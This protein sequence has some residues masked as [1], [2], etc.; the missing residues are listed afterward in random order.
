MEYNNV[1]RRLELGAAIIAF[2]YSAIALFILLLDFVKTS[3]IFEY[4]DLY[5]IAGYVL[6]YVIFIGLF[7]VEIL[8]AIQLF[9]TPIWIRLDYITGEGHFEGKRKQRIGFIAVSSVFLL[10]FLI[11]SV[12]NNVAI[13]EII[14]FLT[15]IML[16]SIAFR[17]KDEKVNAIRNKRF[18]K[19]NS[20]ISIETK[21]AE[22]KH[23]LDLGVITQE[24][25]E[26]AV[27]KAVKQIL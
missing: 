5:Q 8:L 1:K 24:Q 17:M 14:I 19:Y 20:N 10:L 9:I 21:I 6:A 16:E 18:N 2:V 15:V 23:L 26:N 13:L 3:G 27:N 11:S 25:F 22:L 12:F 4:L 7:I